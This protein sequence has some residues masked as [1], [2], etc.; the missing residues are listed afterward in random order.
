MKNIV[1]FLPF[2]T[3]KLKA[4]IWIQAIAR[5]GVYLY[6]CCFIIPKFL[7]IKVL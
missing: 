2:Q 5:A 1:K 4:D 6:V 7:I 3:G